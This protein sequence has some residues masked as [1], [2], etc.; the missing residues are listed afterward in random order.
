MCGVADAFVKS[1]QPMI[2]YAA[3]RLS[4]ADGTG[5]ALGRQGDRGLRAGP[6]RMRSSAR[7]TVGTPM[8]QRAVH[9]DARLEHA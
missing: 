6:R 7:T 4:A 2:A 5:R 3:T 1:E 9:E 8:R